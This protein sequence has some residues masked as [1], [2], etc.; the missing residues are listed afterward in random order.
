MS[1]VTPLRPATFEDV[2]AATVRDT[3]A[4]L[5]GELLPSA[6]DILTPEQ[7]AAWLSVSVSTVYREL[8]AG[9]LPGIKVGSQW[10]VSR[11]ALARVMSG[12]VLD[13]A[14]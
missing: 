11:S 4:D 7:V 9:N 5:I 2:I 3:I 6:D 14:A 1:T 13:G 12:P 10:R 8:R